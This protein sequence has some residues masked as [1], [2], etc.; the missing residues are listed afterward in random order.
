MMK[1][2]T[3]YI[4]LITALIFITLMSCNQDTFL[5]DSQTNNSILLENS[6]FDT[7]NYKGLLVKHRFKK[8]F[9]PNK[10]STH[11]KTTTYTLENA[12]TIPEDIFSETLDLISENYPYKDSIEINIE[13]IKNDFID[14]TTEEDFI[15]NIDIIESYYSENLNYEFFT[16]IENNISTIPTNTENKSTSDIKKGVCVAQ[17]AATKGGLYGLNALHKASKEAEE[18]SKNSIFGYQ[19][20]QNTQQDAYRHILWNIYLAKH[21]RHIAPRRHKRID[22]AEHVADAN[23]TCNSKRADYPNSEQMDY[24]NNLIGRKIYENNSSEKVK[25]IKIFS[26]VKSISYEKAKLIA[27]ESVMDSQYIDGSLSASEV[28]SRIKATSDK[29]R[30]THFSLAKKV[31]DLFNHKRWSTN[32]GGFWDTQQWLAGDFNGDGKADLA[33]AMNDGNGGTNIDVHISNGNNAFSIQRWSTNQGGFWDTQQWLAGDFNGDGKT[34]LAK[35]M[36][37]GNG[38]TNIDVHISNGN[39]AFNLQRWATNQG[40]FWDT[41]QWLAGDFNGDGKADL[42]K[43]MNNGNGGTNIDVHIS[44]GDNAF[45][46]QRWATNQGGFWDTQQWLAGDFDGDGKADLAKAMNDG[47][48][49]T[50]IDVHISN[51]NNTFSLQRWATNQGGFWDTQQWLAGDFDGDGKADLAKA[52]N[53]G[54]NLTNI[55]IHLSKS[56]NTFHIGRWATGQ[57]GFWDTQQW[58]TGDFNGN[59]KTDLAKAM[60]NGSG[61]TNID[62]HLY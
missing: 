14:I 52:M 8:N 59:G 60:N 25:W 20:E 33:K 4:N 15:E 19:D 61:S 36:N 54:I 35:T 58:S 3:P 37:D 10:K 31:S 38:G 43:A 41:Q 23:E 39:N 47:N 7:I 18:Q 44:N 9:K 29:N 51:G 11:E 45:N 6:T 2:E 57:G 1:K 42:A 12:H 21:M 26:T 48:G 34:D 46:L 27:K 40:G 24:H 50:N 28:A 49:G 62:V 32:Q 55:D 16:H 17:K 13:M 56:N 5:I 30:P 53:N 22:F